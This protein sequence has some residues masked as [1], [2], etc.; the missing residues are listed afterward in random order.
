[1]L[2]G[3][4]GNASRQVVIEEFLEGVELS[5]FILTDGKNYTLLP[6]AKDYKRIGEG[7]TGLNT[8]GMGCISPVP[9]AD[10][11]FMKQVETE[12]IKPTLN[13]IAKENIDYSG[14]IFFGLINCSGKPYVIEYNVRLG[15]PEAEVII[16]RLQCDL[17]DVFDQLCSGNLQHTSISI[18]PEACATVMLVSGGYPEKY[19]KG[20][21][22]SNIG[23]V[24]DSVV[25]HAG[26]QLSN[27][28]VVTSGG[29]VLAVSTMAATY[30]EALKISYKNAQLIEFDKKYFR[31]DIGFDL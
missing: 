27:A 18:S 20:K 3:K 14:F 11:A 6:E 13:G 21:I 5:V 7:D 4:F 24:T 23:E 15:D 30:E 8:G 9:F 19:E 29:R 31:T 1:M 2:D 12:I 26:T 22:I 25:F 17:L 28:S 10:K 16:P